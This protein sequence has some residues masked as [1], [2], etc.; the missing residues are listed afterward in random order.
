MKTLPT[1][2]TPQVLVLYSDD[3]R[4]V[5]TQVKHDGFQTTFE[6][7]RESSNNGGLLLP[8]SHLEKNQPHKT[9]WYKVVVFI[10]S[11]QIFSRQLLNQL[12]DL[13]HPLLLVL[14]VFTNQLGRLNVNSS[15]SDSTNQMLTIQPI[16]L[17][18]IATSLTSSCLLLVD[19]LTG[20]QI[21][22]SSNT[23]LFQI[24]IA[25]GQ[26]ELNLPTNLSLI[27]QKQLLQQV[28]K[29]LA[30]PQL[31]SSTLL[32]SEALDGQS[33]YQKTTKYLEQC[34]QH[35][36]ASAKFFQPIPLN[37]PPVITDLLP[38]DKTAVTELINATLSPKQQ[39]TSLNQLIDLIKNRL[40]VW[41]KNQE[42]LASKSRQSV[43]EI[44][45]SLAARS[46]GK[47]THQTQDNHL[48]D[49]NNQQT[50]TPA[51]QSLE[52]H[53]PTS[54]SPP[55]QSLDTQLASIF[56]QKRVVEKTDHQSN[57]QHIKSRIRTKSKRRSWLF[58]GG[59]VLTGISLAILF[60][61]G[62]YSLVSSSLLSKVESI[63]SNLR[64][65][66]VPKPP[67][68]LAILIDLLDWQNR[69]YDHLFD[70]SITQR[71]TNSVALAKLLDRLSLVDRNR[72]E[73]NQDVFSNLFVSSQTDLLKIEQAVALQNVQLDI[74]QELLPALQNNYHEEI[75]PALEKDI[76]SLKSDQAILAN[77]SPHLSQILGFDSPKTYAVVFQNTQELRSTGGFVQS[78]GTITVDKGQVTSTQTYSSYEID[79]MLGGVVEP[80]EDLVKHLGEKQLYFRDSNW[81]PNFPSSAE[82]M[83]WFIEKSLN[84]KLDGVLAITTASLQDI[85]LVTGP[86]VLPDSNQTISAQSL[87]ERLESNSG[88]Q[89][90]TPNQPREYS[91]QVLGV[92]LDQLTKLS[93]EQNK[94]LLIMLN[95]GLKDANTLVFHKDPSIQQA[96]VDLG[97]S[98]AVLSPPCPNPFGQKDCRIDPFY[99]NENNIGINQANS[100]LQRKNQASIKI[101]ESSIKYRFQISYENKADVSSWPK[102]SY[103]A[104]ARAFLPP[105]AEGLKISVNGAEI[106]EKQLTMANWEDRL[107]AGFN[108]EVPIKSGRQVVIEFETP[109]LNDQDA[110]V[111]FMQK[112]PGVSLQQSQ[113]VVDLPNGKVPQQVS[114]GA[115]VAENQVVFSP[116]PNPHLLVGLSF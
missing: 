77:L 102:G 30:A 25:L 20:K 96:M 68:G 22:A 15:T 113:V 104:Y 64:V 115:E 93:P 47:S 6:V 95:Q 65:D 72:R 108:F 51:I 16:L 1:S 36:V 97:W 58:V 35:K 40:E 105:N 79:K 87:L 57:T 114:P 42:I 26:A 89:G 18:Q 48:V 17:S 43:V 4:G 3:M 85:L 101:D 27:T 90:L 66:Q 94:Q 63:T 23:T 39:L 5:A 100:Y 34:Y 11:F 54:Q 41:T 106:P 38:S 21:V 14:P 86:L 116:T 74:W 55:D 19:G 84:T 61:V 110:Y 9:D 45:Q 52:I 53:Q 83:V 67:P 44:D 29:R 10:S 37:I 60:F 33:L 24:A 98:G 62:A 78:L 50:P 56:A 12:G 91:A 2:E 71:P 49:D 31:G 99:L 76:D 109:H 80:P 8:S 88:V 73:T 46:V 103:L 92:V 81:N 7:L 69:F 111:F 28:L 75:L 13:K 32:V 59:A 112:Q 82:T 107:V 70:D